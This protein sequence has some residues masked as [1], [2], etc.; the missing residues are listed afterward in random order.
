MET[1]KSTVVSEI[2][3]NENKTERYLYR[4]TWKK[5][6]NPKL[7][8]VLTKF[9]VNDEPGMLDLT[10]M[11][12]S[13]EIYGLG[14]YDGFILVN[15]SSRLS[16]RT[17]LT[18]KDFSEENDDVILRVFNDEHVQKIIIAVGSII[19]TNKEA[20]LKVHELIGQLPSERKEIVEVLVG[21]NGP[22]H[23]LSPEARS[24]G[25][26]KLSKAKL[27]KHQ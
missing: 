5:S 26:W 9:P 17:S 19:K 12:I 16:P 8:C 22:I 3:T 20:A 21:S 18:E 27:K 11:L 13:N 1:I 24:R 4:R 7:V 15:L 25:G 6:K 23:P 10:T 14:E 2:A